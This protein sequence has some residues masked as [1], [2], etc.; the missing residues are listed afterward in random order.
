MKKIRIIGIVAI[1]TIS[2]LL[3]TVVTIRWSELGCD[4]GSLIA[5]YAYYTSVTCVLGV[6]VIER[7][8][9]LLKH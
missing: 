9:K 1:A 2:L 7:V 5:G 3:C 4:I 8:E 6:M